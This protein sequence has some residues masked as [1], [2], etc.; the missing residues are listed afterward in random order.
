MNMRF[1]YLILAHNN[2]EQLKLLIK[3]LDYQG[4]DI[5]IHLDKKLGNVN[6]CQFENITSYSKVIFLDDRVDVAWAR[7]SIVE[8]TL[9]L[10]ERAIQGNYDYYHMLSGVDFPI[11][12]NSYIQNFF[13]ENCNKEFVGI[14]PYFNDKLFS[15]RV[16]RYH[17]I[18]GNKIRKYKLWSY[19][20]SCLIYMQAILN[21]YHYKSV[22]RFKGGPAWFSISNNLAIDLINKERDLLKGY[23]YTLYPDELFLQTF[24][25]NSEYRNHLNKGEDD[26]MACMRKIDWKRGKPYTWKLNDYEELKAAPH[27]FARKIDYNLAVKLLI[28]LSK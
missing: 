12:K 24:I 14:S 6:L 13:R 5:F 25:W 21:I 15:Q 18:N 3:A 28:D 1:A 26:Y 2:F 27:L 11:K 23:K 16:G 20:N 19:L 10:L 9:K 4:N 7:V 8:A 22:E 17:W